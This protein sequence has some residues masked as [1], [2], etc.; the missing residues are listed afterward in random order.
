[1]LTVSSV[2]KT[3]TIN[4]IDK[5]IS[6]SKV[7]MANGG[8]NLRKWKWSG[9]CN[10]VDF[11]EECQILGLIWNEMSDNFSDHSQLYALKSTSLR[12]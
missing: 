5:Y 4:K 2:T 9:E 1:M 7:F 8:F 3:S 12:M 11:K 10:E 6:N